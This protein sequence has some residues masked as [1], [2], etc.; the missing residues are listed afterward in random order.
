MRQPPRLP[1]ELR[2]QLTVPFHDDIRR[3]SQLIGRD[4]DHW[5]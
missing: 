4:L 3:T 5:L 2:K 1:S